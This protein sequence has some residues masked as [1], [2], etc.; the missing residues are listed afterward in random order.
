MRKAT[1]TAGWRKA[2]LDRL[3]PGCPVRDYQQW[4][5]QAA[6]L[7]DGAVGFWHAFEE[8]WSNTRG[9]ATRLKGSGAW[10]APLGAVH[11]LTEPPRMP[12]RL[13]SRGQPAI[14]M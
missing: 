3:D 14:T 6:H 7:A 13:V 9:I 10:R 12:W 5:G 4:I 2:N 8:V 1:L 11:R